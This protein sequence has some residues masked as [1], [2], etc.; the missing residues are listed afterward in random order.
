MPALAVRP[1]S[2][3]YTPEL[4]ER[5]RQQAVGKAEAW[6]GLD[7][8]AC[9]MGRFVVA[10]ALKMPNGKRKVGDIVQSVEWTEPKRTLRPVDSA[11][12]FAGEG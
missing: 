3:P 4:G 10:A 7:S 9:G 6:N 5:R 11:L 1:L 12:G 8:A 2:L